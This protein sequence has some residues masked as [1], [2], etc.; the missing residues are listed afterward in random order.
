[1]KKIIATL[2][3]LG[4]VTAAGFVS[5]ESDPTNDEAYMDNILDYND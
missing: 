5:A 4:L 2:L 1:M 3:A